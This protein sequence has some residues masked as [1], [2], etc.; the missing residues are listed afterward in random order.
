MYEF[1]DTI[2]SSGGMISS[3]LPAEAMSINGIYIENEIEGYRTLQV[4]G[5]EQQDSE[6]GDLQLGNM[7]GTKFLYKRN[8]PRDIKVTFR[9]LSSSPEEFRSKFNQLNSI[10]DQD[11]AEIRFA[12]ETDKFFVGTKN[13]GPE[14]DGG[15][16]NVTGEFT[17][18]CSD[19]FKYGAEVSVSIGTEDSKTVLVQGMRETP[20]VIEVTPPNGVISFTIKGV[21]RDPV[22]GEAED[23]LIKNLS[24]GKTVVINGEDDTVLEDGMNKFADTEMWEF[25]SLLPG[26]NILSFVSSSVPCD[27]TIKYKPRYI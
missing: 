10:L 25:P 13:S 3:G 18:H 1:V 26:E 2:E 8:E 12:D 20:C 27:V 9:I 15:L 23:I 17:I 11:E 7:D 21:A 22:T 24:A 14:V 5:R 19:P 4:T 16:L 6:I